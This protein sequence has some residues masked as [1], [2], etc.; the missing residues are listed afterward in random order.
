ME[1]D[2]EC[3]SSYDSPFAEHNALAIVP[4][5]LESGHEE[6]CR[7]LESRHEKTCREPIIADM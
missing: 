2:N 7:T 3:E 6:T 1:S 4:S 5:G